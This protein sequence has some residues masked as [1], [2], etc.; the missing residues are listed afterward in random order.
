MADIE[1]ELGRVT[2]S[3]DALRTKTCIACGYRYLRSD[4]SDCCSPR[5]AGYLADG[6]PSKAWQLKLDDRFA[7]R[8]RFRSDRKIHD[9]PWL[10]R[11][12]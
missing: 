3:L 10:R 5:C 4:Y 11:Q 6:G 7:D 2:G 8:S 1:H 12:V 9:V